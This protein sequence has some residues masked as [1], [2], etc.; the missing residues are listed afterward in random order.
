MKAKKNIEDGWGDSAYVV[1][2]VAVS[3]LTII[4][5]RQLNEIKPSLNISVNSVH[6]GYVDTDMTNHTGTLTIEEGAIAPLYLAIGDHNLKG[7]YVWCDCKIIDW[8][9]D[10]VKSKLD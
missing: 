6:P 5:Q 2:K 10:T 4:Q 1:S 3:A 7:E 8:Y 9:A